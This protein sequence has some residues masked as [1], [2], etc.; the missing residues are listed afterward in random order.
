[1]EEEKEAPQDVQFNNLVAPVSITLA[2]LGLTIVASSLEGRE[3]DGDF[4]SKAIVIS[5]SVLIP[6]CI[7][8]SSWLI[9][10]DSGVLRVGSITLAVSL[11]G[12][13][14]NSADPENFNHLFVTT[15]VFVGFASAVLHE[16]ERFEE[17]ANLLSIVLGARL[18]AFYS[19]GLIIAQSD[20][21]AVI[22][23]VRESIG[24]AF[25]SFWLSSISLGFLVMV[26]LRG[27]VE[28]RGKGGLMSNLPNIRD[29]PEVGIYSSLVFASFL[30]PL[31][32]IGQ[33]DSLQDFSQ[34]SHIGVAWASF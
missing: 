7:G 33:I 8:R 26:G 24:A 18:A 11:L 23:T 9:P 32:W 27:T 21:L 28:N 6:A 5:L 20:S 19:G 31:I 22:D 25:F 30:I 13:I 3:V 4:L 15:F 12:V 16:S 1:M 34:Q 29:N 10:L 17:S 14:A 2:L